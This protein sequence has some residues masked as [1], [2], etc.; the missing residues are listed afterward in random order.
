MIPQL[1]RGIAATVALVFVML[2]HEF[3]A[4]L[5]VRSVNTRVMGTALNE[6]YEFGLYLAVAVTSLVM[7]IVT[8]AGVL[9][10]TMIGGQDSLRS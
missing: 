8:M 4:S 9:V 2:T 7:I 5:M 6:A 3:S 1:R 10:A